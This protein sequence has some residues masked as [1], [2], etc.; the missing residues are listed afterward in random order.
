MATQGAHTCGGC[1]VKMPVED[2]H[3]HC[4]RCLG[5]DHARMAIQDPAA[6]MNCFI[7]PERVRE[8]RARLPSLDSSN[9][10]LGQPL[11]AKRLKAAVE[12]NQTAVQP[13]ATAT[14]SSPHEPVPAI[15]VGQEEYLDEEDEEADVDV[16]GLDLDEDEDDELPCGQE[17][18]AAAQDEPS[19][20]FS[21]IARA[22]QALQMELPSVQA[23]RASRFDEGEDRPCPPSVPLLSDVEDLVLEQF[24]RP[25]TA[26]RWSGASR[27]MASVDGRERIGC[28]PPPPMDPALA[29]LISPATTSVLGNPSCSTKNTR[30]MDVM[31]GRIHGVL[32]VQGQLVNQ[33]ARDG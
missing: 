10:A 5:P 3:D 15:E 17:E 32:S 18:L 22:A 28:G 14:V 21:I 6:C 30:A 2:G 29:P 19:L 12:N 24:T 33:L 25:V 27:R 23:R 11:P 7:L 20:F 31:L 9:T 13:V 26:F 16:L 8:A 1:G 4:V